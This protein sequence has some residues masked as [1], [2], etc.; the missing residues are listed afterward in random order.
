M[1]NDDAPFQNGD[2]GNTHETTNQEDNLF[3]NQDE[4]REDFQISTLL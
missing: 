2:Y 4:K 1:E 3:G